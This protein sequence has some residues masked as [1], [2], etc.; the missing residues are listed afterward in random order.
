MTSDNL[1]RKTFYG[2]TWT[3][4]KNLSLQLFGFIQGIILARLLDPSAY[5][6]I[7]MIQVFFAVSGV[8]IDSGFS[9]A[10][11]RKKERTEIDYSTVFITN[12]VLTLFFACLLIVCA[13]FIAKFYHEPILTKIVRANAIL[14]ILN[15]FNATQGARMI[16]N[17]QF[18]EISIISVIVNVSVGLAS[19]ACAFAG[20]GIWSLI[21][22]NYLAPFLYL[23]LYWH[24]QHWRPKIQF[25]WK[26]WKEFF[27]YGSR[28]LASALLDTVFKNI[29]PIIIGK[30]FSATELGYYNR[31]R[32]YSN[33]P[34]HTFQSMIGQVS[35]QV[36][37]EI[38]DDD[39]RLRTG[40]RRL[41]RMSA[42][43]VFP[44]MIGL[45]VLAK[46]AVLVLITEKWA[47]SIPMLQIL[48][49]SSM[50]YPVH[51]LNLSLLQVKGRSDLFL[52]LEIVKKAILLI[53]IFIAVPFGVIGICVSSIVTSLIA[54]SINTHYT[55]KLI[56]L[57][58]FQQMKDLMP[59]LLFSALM[60]FVVLLITTPIHSMH[61]KLLIGIPCGGAF[62]YGIAKMS[63]SEELNYVLELLNTYIIKRRK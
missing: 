44:L 4:A 5:G 20:L 60:G 58:F 14:L 35:F 55:G 40:Y 21:W 9:N 61:L 47:A 11:K 28:L 12:V 33:L 62:Y 41:I 45:A 7:A 29:Y 36:L 53:A 15:S 43:V 52:R 54:L 51:A 32:G 18:K 26:S 49:F 6:L 13:P 63:H 10:L 3:F 59:S 23:I 2:M 30:K 8:F 56:N 22:P 42:F 57:G 27:A 24:Y 50:W 37:S 34:S 38:Q 31:A 1:Q 17:F 19:I 48:C 39:T 16:I 46:P 25:S